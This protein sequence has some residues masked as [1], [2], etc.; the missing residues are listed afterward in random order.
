M[1]RARPASA[2]RLVARTTSKRFLLA[3]PS[4]KAPVE[5]WFDIQE[6][7][8]RSNRI[9]LP[10]YRELDFVEA[11]NRSHDVETAINRSLAWRRSDQPA[12][13]GERATGRA[14]SWSREQRLSDFRSQFR[15]AGFLPAVD[16][17]REVIAAFSVGRGNGRQAPP[18]RSFAIGGSRC[19]RMCRAKPA[20][21]SRLVA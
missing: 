19:P 5:R 16:A 6:S 7:L 8:N 14:C 17:A 3:V 21:A 18:D 15:P 12:G 1:C 11:P 13:C 9:Y 2:S 20:G 10:E 4:S